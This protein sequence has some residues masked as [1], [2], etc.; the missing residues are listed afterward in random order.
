M[1]FKSSCSAASLLAA[2]VISS[3]PGLAHAVSGQWDTPAAG[4]SGNGASSAQPWVGTLPAGA[5]VAE[6]NF[7]NALS[8]SVPDIAGSGSLVETSGAAFVT[9]G[10]NVYSFS[11]PTA[12]TATLDALAAGSWD[13]YLR[14]ST[15]GNAVNPAATL[16]GVSA[17][18]T[19]TYSEAITGGFGGGEEESLWQW[20]GVSG[21]AN[22]V[23]NFA[24]STS[25]M[26]LDQVALLAV[27]SPVPEPTT[28]ALMGAGL[29]ALGANSLRRRASPSA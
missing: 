10:G 11:A 17:T 14:V 13:V 27:P 16:N 25:S 15:L 18:R 24:A 26:S 21:G 28:W 2:L 6:W 9:G 23:F 7:I 22:L 19:L 8:D 4:H 20:S 12:F 5:R 29:A 1:Y 3:A